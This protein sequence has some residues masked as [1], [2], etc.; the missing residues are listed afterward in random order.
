MQYLEEW[1]GSHS[2]NST[3][4]D[5]NYSPCSKITMF[6][7]VG[8][9]EC[10]IIL[11][12]KIVYQPTTSWLLILMCLPACLAIRIYA[13]KT[14]EWRCLHLEKD[15]RFVSDSDPW[16]TLEIRSIYIWVTLERYEITFL[17]Y[18]SQYLDNM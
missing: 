5:M 18:S 6:F 15:F 9:C 11:W 1:N 10:V 3:K 13:I 2:Q 12:Q 16:Q 7:I 4:D 14:N 17:P 8:I